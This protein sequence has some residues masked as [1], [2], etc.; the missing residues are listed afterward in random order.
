MLRSLGFWLLIGAILGVEQPQSFQGLVWGGFPGHALAV[1]IILGGG[2]LLRPLV[3]YS[4]AYAGRFFAFG[5]GCAAAM[6]CA[7]LLTPV[8]DFMGWPTTWDTTDAFFRPK[9]T[10]QA[11]QAVEVIFGIPFSLA[12]AFAHKI[13]MVAF[14]LRNGKPRWWAPLTYPP[15]FFLNV[16]TPVTWF[17]YFG[18]LTPLIVR[19]DR[20]LA[21][22][23]LN[24]EQISSESNLP[25]NS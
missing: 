9:H 16:A 24:R 23:Q 20:Y 25:E 18:L 6:L 7:L 5:A 22:R 11:L 19:I 12:V 1:A 13:G 21:S 17:F 2:L 10:K 4:E 15:T 14:V 3:R 8:A